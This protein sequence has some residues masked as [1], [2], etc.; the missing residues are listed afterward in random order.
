M[1]KEPHICPKCKDIYWATLSRCPACYP[2][3]EKN[4]DK[5]IQNAAKMLASNCYGDKANI[6]DRK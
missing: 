6:Q 2:N 3:N 1:D 5:Y 4:I